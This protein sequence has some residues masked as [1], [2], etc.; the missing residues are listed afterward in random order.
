MSRRL[1]GLRLKALKVTVQGSNRAVLLRRTLWQAGAQ[2]SL[3]K[4]SLTAH[5]GKQCEGPVGQRPQPVA[6]LKCIA[7][8][9]AIEEG[10]KQEREA[11]M[12]WL[13]E[14]S[15]PGRQC[16]A[17]YGARPMERGRYFENKGKLARQ[18]GDGLSIC[19]EH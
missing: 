9:A 13:D 1:Q 7:Y 16:R 8:L 18:G 4:Q 3:G 2:V 10:P 11:F 12:R 15:T 17:H 14:N 19:E 5:L 6:Y